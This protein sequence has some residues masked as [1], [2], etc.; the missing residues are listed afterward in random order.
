MF[1]MYVNKTNCE[2]QKIISVYKLNESSN[3]QTANQGTSSNE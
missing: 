2:I 1:F 3:A